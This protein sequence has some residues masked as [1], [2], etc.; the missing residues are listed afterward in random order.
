M[1]TAGTKPRAGRG[2]ER[3]RAMLEAATDVFIEKG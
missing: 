3:A 1:P 2:S